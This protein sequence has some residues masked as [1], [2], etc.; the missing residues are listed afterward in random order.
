MRLQFARIGGAEFQFD[1]QTLNGAV[2][3]AGLALDHVAG[4]RRQQRRAARIGDRD[5]SAA[6]VAARLDAHALQAGSRDLNNEFFRRA[7]GLR[8]PGRR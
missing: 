8:Q 2:A 3:R 6:R 4:R 5:P 7:H 1:A